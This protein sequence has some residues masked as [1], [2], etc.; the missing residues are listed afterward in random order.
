MSHHFAQE[1]GLA[2]D[3]QS[4]TAIRHS[5]GIEGIVIAIPDL[6]WGRTLGDAFDNDDVFYEHHVGEVDDEG[7]YSNGYVKR[8]DHYVLIHVPVGSVHEVQIETGY[9]RNEIP[10][11]A[12]VMGG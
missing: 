5:F 2:H 8:G 10:D 1:E 11:H 9:H 4:T 12:F 3:M 6:V 7:Y